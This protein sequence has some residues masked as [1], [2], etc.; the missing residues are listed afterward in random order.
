MLEY[1]AEGLLPCGPKMLENNK[2][3]LKEIWGEC[4]IIKIAG[5]DKYDGLHVWVKC[6]CG[7]IFTTRYRNLTSGR[8]TKCKGHLRNGGIIG[9][10]IN[11]IEILEIVNIEPNENGEHII[12]KCKCFCGEEFTCRYNN[13]TQGNTMSCGCIKS[14]GEEVCADVLKNKN[15]RYVR[16][17]TFPDLKDKRN[18]SYDFFLPD[19][20]VLIEI[21]GSFHRAELKF[22][23][24]S[25]L[26]EVQIHD[27]MKNN[28]AI[29]NNL[30]L[31]RFVYEDYLGNK[32]LEKLK[33]NI[34]NFL[35]E[36]S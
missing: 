21:D 1:P 26:K 5:K 6:S 19:Y 22:T 35:E 2:K 24:H 34:I 28:Y 10:K 32:G 23:S 14:K 4:V 33:N 30:L 25:N 11:N 12:V 9:K 3:H 27:E 17:K 7:T 29:K 36:M 31:K 18:L 20:N 15:I 16:Q 13:L 8:T